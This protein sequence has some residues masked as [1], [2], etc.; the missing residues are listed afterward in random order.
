M[1]AL[2]PRSPSF[3][4][5]LPHVGSR[6]PFCLSQ[7]AHGALAIALGSLPGPDAFV[8][9]STSWVP[10]AV[11]C[12]LDCTAGAR[13]LSVPVPMPLAAPTLADRAPL[14]SMRSLAACLGALL[15]PLRV[16]LVPLPFP[17]SLSRAVPSAARALSPF[18]AADLGIVPALSPSLLAACALACSLRLSLGTPPVA[19]RPLLRAPVAGTLP[20]LRPSP[21]CRITRRASCC[22]HS[23]GSVTP[24]GVRLAAGGRTCR[25]CPVG[26]AAFGGNGLGGLVWVWLGLA[27]ARYL[28]PFLPSAAA[29][30][31]P[32]EALGAR[33]GF[34]SRARGMLGAA[35][36]PAGAVA[37]HAGA[38]LSAPCAPSRPS[39]AAAAAPSEAPGARAGATPRA[40]GAP[41]AAVRAA[42][43][44]AGAA[45]SAPSAPGGPSGGGAA[46]LAAW[47]AGAVLSAGAGPRV[48]GP[49]SAK[50]ARGCPAGGPTG[51]AAY[52]SRSSS[53]S[54]RVSP[55]YPW[56]TGERERDRRWWGSSRLGEPSVSDITVIPVGMRGGRCALPTTNR[57]IRVVPWAVLCSASQGEGEEGRVAWRWP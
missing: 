14:H 6:A 25:V 47:A 15:A 13:I 40:G 54:A 21:P 12:A 5:A 17:G 1:R 32:G 8:P 50:A 48:D 10:P 49:V 30:V 57:F 9:L 2:R 4:S 42:A 23:C 38:A 22:R 18:A 39:S 33:A 34:I 46:G 35:A 45:V 41:G 3:R 53:R 19:S 44:L 27:W 55:A 7:G 29:V 43:R 28:A 52:A 26:K 37:R 36:W 51:T 24:G 31:A 11:T 20:R 16:L 56:E